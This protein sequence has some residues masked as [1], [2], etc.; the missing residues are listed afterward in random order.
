[1]D[2]KEKNKVKIRNDTP[3]TSQM[4]QCL[5]LHTSMSGSSHFITGQGIKVPQAAKR[6]QKTKTKQKSS[7]VL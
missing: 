5:R 3:G 7:K 2:I 4:A 6:G 1:M